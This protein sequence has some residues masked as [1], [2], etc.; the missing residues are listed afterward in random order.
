MTYEEF[1]QLIVEDTGM[2]VQDVKKVLKS[3]D[4]CLLKGLLT[5]GNVSLDIG[6]FRMEERSEKRGINPRTGEEIVIAAKRVV[7]FRAS[8]SLKEKI[9]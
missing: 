3:F 7:N 5:T 4:N 9:R 6:T 8:D 2:P 1:I